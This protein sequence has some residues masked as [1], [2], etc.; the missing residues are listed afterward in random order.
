MVGMRGVNEEPSIEPHIARFLLKYTLRRSS[1]AVAPKPKI[2]LVQ[3]GKVTRRLPP[4]L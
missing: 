3:I 1:G 2:W 4:I